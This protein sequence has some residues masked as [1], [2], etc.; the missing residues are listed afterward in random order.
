MFQQDNPDHELASNK[1]RTCIEKEKEKRVK[2]NS[3]DKLATPIP[4]KPKPIVP[5]KPTFIPPPI[6]NRQSVLVQSASAQRSTS[7]RNVN[8]FE[9]LQ[10]SPHSARVKCT[11]ST[12]SHIVPS[13]PN[14]VCSNDCCGIPLPGTSSKQQTN[15]NNNN[16]NNNIKEVGDHLHQPMDHKRSSNDSLD[17]S[18]SISSNSGGFKDP[19]YIARQNEFERKNRIDGCKLKMIIGDIDSRFHVSAPSIENPPTNE[20]QLAVIKKQLSEP[21]SRSQHEQ[22]SNR[23]TKAGQNSFFQQST[24][25]L[26]QMLA[27]RIEKE[28]RCV[29]QQHQNTKKKRIIAATVASKTDAGNCVQQIA[30][31]QASSAVCQPEPNIS[32]IQKQFQHKLHDEMKLHCKTIQEKHLIEKRWPQLHYTAAIDEDQSVNV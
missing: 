11:K 10:N 7:F 25:Q 22:V 5:A 12:S 29:P 6:N 23:N 21:T 24:K 3:G 32:T 20:S 15:H 30:T 26:E 27:Q 17:C 16:N 18:S 31:P 8:S 13:S 19:D 4:A 9:N 2:S 1:I 28:N 14:L